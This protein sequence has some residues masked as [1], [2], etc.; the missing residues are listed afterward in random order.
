MT[1]MCFLARPR[2][3]ETKVEIGTLLALKSDA[4]D[5]LF[6]KRMMVS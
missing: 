3:F 5:H 4:K 6:G 2:T 1:G